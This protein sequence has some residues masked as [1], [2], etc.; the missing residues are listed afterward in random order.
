MLINKKNVRD[1]ESRKILDFIEEEYQ[2]K[3]FCRRWLDQAGFKTNF[4]LKLLTK[5]GII[6]NFP[7]LIEKSKSP[8]SQFEETIIFH[9]Q[10]KII[11]TN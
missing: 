11:T 4:S 3:P 6:Y 10:K 1:N 7:V 9:E 8:V 5:Q 2:T